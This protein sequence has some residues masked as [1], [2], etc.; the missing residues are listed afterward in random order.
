MP[1]MR[2]THALRSALPADG[3]APLRGLFVV[4][5]RAGTSVIMPSRRWRP[6]PC[7]GRGDP[8][9]SVTPRSTKLSEQPVAGMVGGTDDTDPVEEDV[10][11]LATRFRE[12]E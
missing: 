1:R 3:E 10:A 11:R 4:R 6:I 9:S 8:P 7:F 5:L 12:E 2:V